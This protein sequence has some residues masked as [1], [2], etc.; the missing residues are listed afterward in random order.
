V[1]F[2]NYN[3]SE[4]ATEIDLALLSSTLDKVTLFSL[5]QIP[6]ATK[7]IETISAMVFNKLALKK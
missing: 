6:E 3:I 4:V 7:D 5:F 2:E 1:S